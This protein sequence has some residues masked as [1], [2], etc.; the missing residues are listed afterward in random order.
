M[1]F[2]LKVVAI[3]WF[4]TPRPRLGIDQVITRPLELD[5]EAEARLLRELKQEQEQFLDRLLFVAI[6]M[7]RFM[8]H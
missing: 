4:I 6:E 2:L 7:A 8:D 3:I 1:S 5:T